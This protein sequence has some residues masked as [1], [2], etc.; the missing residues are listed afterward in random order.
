MTETTTKA[1]RIFTISEDD[2]E[3]ILPGAN[4]GR[5]VFFDTGNAGVIEVYID[6]DGVT[7]CNGGVGF[8]VNVSPRARD[9]IYV[10]TDPTT[11]SA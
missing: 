1:P 10:T 2:E 4:P 5:A 3:V 7:V 9:E 8:D 6:G 11:A